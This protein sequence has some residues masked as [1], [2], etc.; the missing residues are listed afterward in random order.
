MS[1]LNPFYYSDNP[2]LYN[3]GYPTTSSAMFSGYQNWAMAPMFYNNLSVP[4]VISSAY[5]AAGIYSGAA[6]GVLIYAALSSK[7]TPEAVKTTVVSN[8]FDIPKTSKLDSFKVNLSKTLVIPAKTYFLL[9]FKANSSDSSA[10]LSIARTN[11]SS[12]ART[13]YNAQSLKTALTTSDT[14]TKISSKD[15]WHNQIPYIYLAYSEQKIKPV[16]SKTSITITQGSSTSVSI[17]G[18]SN[19][20]IAGS[21]SNLTLTKSGNTLKIK[22]GYF[23]L[24]TYA[25][26]TVTINGLNAST[27]IVVKIVPPTFNAVKISNT[28]IKPTQSTAI[29]CTLSDGLSAIISSVSYS[30]GSSAITRT[31]NKFAVSGIVSDT[32][33]DWAG[34]AI[35]TTVAT[36]TLKHPNNASISKTATFTVKHWASSDI[37]VNVS[38][39]SIYYDGSLTQYIDY[40]DMTLV[41]GKCQVYSTAD[42]VVIND[43]N[44]YITGAS[45][46]SFDICAKLVNDFVVS[47]TIKTISIINSSI[48]LSVNKPITSSTALPIF[49]DQ[50][51]KYNPFCYPI[52]L[53]I[54]TDISD[55]STLKIENIKYDDTLVAIPSDENFILVQNLISSSSIAK[56][57]EYALVLKSL[58]D[59]TATSAI[60]EGSIHTLKFSFSYISSGSVLVESSDFII[61]LKIYR[62]S[63]LH[64][65]TN[66]YNNANI[67][68]QPFSL[69]SNLLQV[70][71]TPI[72]SILVAYNIVLPANLPN[73]MISVAAGSIISNATDKAT[74]EFYLTK[75]NLLIDKINT[76]SPRQITRAREHIALDNFIMWDDSAETLANLQLNT[77]KFSEA[78]LTSTAS[79]WKELFIAMNNIQRTKI[80]NVVYQNNSIFYNNNQITAKE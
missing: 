67:Q 8:S 3:I 48:P 30:N 59:L 14:I 74:I 31:D 51:N 49:V 58:S 63:I 17:S 16:V 44:I 64:F 52:Y 1:R 5:V 66:K 39:S 22:A 54:P 9:G 19:W 79:P 11:T 45:P 26:R 21:V 18:Y 7:T 34:T 37:S 68:G 57:N 60:T 69:S 70:L 41:P 61:R 38:A 24:S 56:G 78:Y 32:F 36:V 12:Y 35:G 29:T 6:T 28:I 15:I 4:I 20:S 13:L 73:A 50:N 77:F 55:M 23:N 43:N 46:V 27:S 65:F 53:T 42:N 75:L 72:D 33:T 10:Y 80:V 62:T 40:S 25:N 71:K 76:D 2:S 47:S